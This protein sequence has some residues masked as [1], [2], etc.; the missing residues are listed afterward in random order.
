MTS[1]VRSKNGTKSC[2]EN[3]LYEWKKMMRISKKDTFVVITAYYCYETLCAR[4]LFSSFFFSL[5]IC[6]Q[7]LGKPRQ[8]T[9]LLYMEHNEMA[10]T[11]Q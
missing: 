11:L 7:I 2:S 9:I 8:L 4:P 3:R 10:R 5:L 1:D 6:G